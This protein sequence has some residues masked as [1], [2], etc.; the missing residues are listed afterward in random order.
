M[1]QRTLRR[2]A[3]ASGMTA[4]AMILFVVASLGGIAAV[5]LA[6]WGVGAFHGIGA[7]G[8]IALLLGIAFTSILGVGLMGLIFYSDRSNM[9]EDAQGVAVSRSESAPSASEEQGSKH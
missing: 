1:L 8:A 2:A 4:R 3:S 9:D 5:L 6:L 7:G